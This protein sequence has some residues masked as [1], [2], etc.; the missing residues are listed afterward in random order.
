M[1]ANWI[2]SIEIQLLG[3]GYW[4]N[5]LPGPGGRNIDNFDYISERLLLLNDLNGVFLCVVYSKPFL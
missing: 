4:N 2:P 5:L 3:T 1:Y